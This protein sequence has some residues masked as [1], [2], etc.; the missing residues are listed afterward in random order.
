VFGVAKR[1]PIKV[2]CEVDADP[3][4]V[5]FR[6]SFNNS[7]EVMAVK[8]FIS[9][10][11]RSIATYAPRTKYGYGELYCW[12]KNRVGEQSEPCVFT[13]IPAGP[14]QPVRNCLVGNQST[15]GLIVKCEMGEDGGLEQQFFLE[16]Y[17]S[18]DGQ[19]QSN[20]TSTKA[21]VFEVT[22]L[23]IATSFV[24]VLYAANA[25]GRS[26]Y[27]TL[28]GSSAKSLVSDDFS[29]GALRMYSDIQYFFSKHN[30]ISFF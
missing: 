24:L 15:D 28:T 4:Q 23:P 25:K 11:T 10:K 17:Q 13:V 18:E 5:T 9:A 16:I 2:P 27:V 7:F 3:P 1:E 29:L 21:P 8:N 30:Y 20:W 26:N 22:G 14:P 12:A 6:W 19:L